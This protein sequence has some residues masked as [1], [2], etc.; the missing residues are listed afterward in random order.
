MCCSPDRKRCG[1]YG[2][3]RGLVTC[4]RRREAGQSAMAVAVQNCA[5]SADCAAGRVGKVLLP[6]VGQLSSLTCLSL[7]HSST[8]SMMIE[9]TA[10][11]H[12]VER[13]EA[14]I[15]SVRR[16]SNLVSIVC[17]S[18]AIQ[19]SPAVGLSFACLR[20]AFCDLRDGN[21]DPGPGVKHRGQGS[22][23]RVVTWPGCLWVS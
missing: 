12:C 10:C 8:H 9:K 20:W 23:G 19:S 3:V 5:E 15:L 4:R 16:G 7:Q 13:G 1:P 2:G 18:P 11:I 14:A 6:C 21:C 22:P 17:S